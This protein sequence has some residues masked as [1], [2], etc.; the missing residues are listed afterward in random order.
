VKR[1]S[2]GSGHDHRVRAGRRR[3]LALALAITASFTVVEVV[4]GFLTGSLAVLADA[5]HMLAD[6]VSIALALFAVWLSAKPATPERT[7]GYKR[8]EVLAAL[9]N[10]VTL[11][12][13][14]IW[15]F[16]EAFRRLADPEEVLA[17]WM[18]A[19]AVVGIG[20]NLAAGAVLHRA[21]EDSLN[22]EAAF[23]HVFADLLG[24]LGVALA[25]VIILATGW[26]QADA[27]VSIFIGALILASSWSILRD[28]TTILLE[29]APKGIETPLV[30]QRLAGAPG[31][32]EVHDLHIWTITSGF[33]A[34]S[35]HVLVGRGEDCHQRRRELEHLLGDEFGIAHTT[36]QVD[37][38]GETG[39]LVE[40][41]RF[42]KMGQ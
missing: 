25:A 18:L 31:V 19:I 15:I 33:P 38:A 41:G 11:V 42:G 5:V 2:V 29:G 35:A 20:A 30:G 32:V 6:N 7:F 28:A 17:G 36:L 21:R 12:A 9:A 16:V 4:G 8:A 3:A 26:L 1:V 24:S 10:G 22:V 14:A 23:R 37:H 34:L 27:L 39:G 13:L 40:I